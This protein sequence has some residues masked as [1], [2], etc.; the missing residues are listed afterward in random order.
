M[1]KVLISPG[2]GAGWSTWQHEVTSEFA[3]QYEPLIKAVEAGEDIDEDHPAIK[4][5]VEDVKEKFTDEIFLPT[6]INLDVR[7]IP[8][9]AEY[10]VTVYDGNESLEVK[11]EQEWVE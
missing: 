11:D 10:K 2:Y 3:T 7:T 9:D 6:R 4:Q 5:Y 8:D 1:K